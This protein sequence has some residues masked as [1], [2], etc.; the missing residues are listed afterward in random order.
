M[1]PEAA[2][3]TKKQYNGYGQNNLMPLQLQQGNGTQHEG[4]TVTVYI[5][6]L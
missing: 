6:G 3:T 1:M 5:L 2:G 4:K